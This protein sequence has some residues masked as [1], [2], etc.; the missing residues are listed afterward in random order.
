MVLT[1]SLSFSSVSTS[2]ETNASL[3]DEEILAEENSNCDVS[4]VQISGTT[5]VSQYS[6]YNYTADSPVGNC[7]S[8]WTVHGGTIVSQ[9]TQSQP[10]Y[11]QVQWTDGYTG[12]VILTDSNWDS[13]TYIY[14]TIN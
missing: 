12:A 14:V 11:V 10:I 9:N 2:K 3:N 5:N 4:S 8:V 7:N 6:T 13:L 1:V